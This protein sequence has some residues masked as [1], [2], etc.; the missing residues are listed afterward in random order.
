MTGRAPAARRPWQNWRLALLL[1]L[2]ACFVGLVAAEAFHRHDSVAAGDACVL[3]Q[4][5]AH[6]PLDATLSGS[7]LAPPLLVALYFIARLRERIRFAS[8]SRVLYRSRAPPL[9]F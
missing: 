7:E 9:A 8:P 1:V 4:A 6:P 3:C 5:A 2:L